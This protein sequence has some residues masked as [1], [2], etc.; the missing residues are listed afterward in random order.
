MERIIFSISI[1][2]IST[3]LN[4]QEFGEKVDASLATN[5]QAITIADFDNDGY[6]DIAS[7][8]GNEFSI[9]WAEN[10]G[11]GN[12]GRNGLGNEASTGA[13][14]DIISDDFD[15]DGDIDVMRAIS[16]LE[17]KIAWHKNDG[18]G[19]FSGEIIITVEVDEPRS[20]FSADLNGD[21]LPDLLST[22]R[23]DNK[24][25]WYKNLGDGL[26][27][28][29]I[30]I[31]DETVYGHDIEAAD[32]DLDGDLDIVYGTND[33]K[34]YLCRNNGNESFS[35]P[36]LFSTNEV[37]M[38]RGIKLIDLD[39][40]GKVDILAGGYIWGQVGWFKNLGD[41]TFSDYV[42]IT[43]MPHRVRSVDAADLD[44][45]GDI[46]VVYASQGTP[47][48]GPA[49][50]SWVEN[51]GDQEYGLPVKLN[52]ETTGGTDVVI[53][54][55]NN[56][57]SLDVVSC[58]ALNANKI[59]WYENL[60]NPESLVNIVSF[61][62]ENSNGI[63][64]F[65]ESHLANVPLV[66]NPSGNVHYTNEKGV[67][68]YSYNHLETAISGILP[69]NYVHTNSAI[70]DL[71]SPTSS[72]DTLYIG[73]KPVSVDNKFD[74]NLTIGKAYCN[75]NSPVIVSFQNRGTFMINGSIVLRN[76]DYLE[77]VD[78]SASP[79]PSEV[80]LDAIKWEVKDLLPG[81]TFYASLEFKVDYREES[82]IMLEAESAV[83][84][85]ESSDEIFV[86][87]M[88]TQ[89]DSLVTICHCTGI[90]DK[91]Y[92][93]LN[94]PISAVDS[95]GNDDHSLHGCDIIGVTDLNGD[96]TIDEEDC[97]LKQ[98][99]QD[100]IKIIAKTQETIHCFPSPEVDKMSNPTGEG[101]ANWTLTEQ[102]IEYTIRF[103]NQ[104]G[105]ERTRVTITDFIDENLDIST[106]K[107]LGASHPDVRL[108]LINA[109][110]RNQYK[111]VAD[112]SNIN[113][114]D[115]NVDFAKSQGFIKYSIEPKSFLEDSTEIFNSAKV[116]FDKSRTRKITDTVKNTLVYEI[117]A[118]GPHAFC[119]DNY[120]FF[121]F[122]GSSMEINA[123]EL[124]DGSIDNEGIVSYEVSPAEFD[125]GDLGRPHNV[126]LKVFDIDGNCDSCFTIVD[127]FGD[128]GYSVQ[129]R[130]IAIDVQE[131]GS[132][133]IS[134]LDLTDVFTSG[135]SGFPSMDLS[136]DIFTSEDEGENQIFVYFL[137]DFGNEDSCEAIVTVNLLSDVYTNYR[138]VRM[139]LQPNPSNSFAVLKLELDHPR[140][141]DVSI[142]DLSGKVMLSYFNQFEQELYLDYSILS[143]GIYFLQLYD[144]QTNK[145]MGYL[146]LLKE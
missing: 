132:K 74:L 96:E 19:N 66:I 107:F 139:S 108:Q 83:L 39:L 98:G 8:D 87:E 104:S 85:L 51:L 26:F 70:I 91:P 140:T 134:P 58:H 52:D 106:F 46:D 97:I 65:S 138:D 99:V 137:N 82:Q 113:L 133:M 24:I 130:D 129:C 10:G 78:N 28:N 143:K 120:Q 75:R 121:L 126:R 112:I 15:L 32:L 90:S 55:I 95:L 69:K 9:L 62:D 105:V 38:P 29:Q 100:T 93:V 68:S 117:P 50:V 115:D 22:S 48:V 6:L 17:D 60:M 136:K 81:A 124:D 37:L 88:S 109:P 71:T 125:C 56:D 18:K 16:G 114:P 25:A 77:Y 20:L 67:L 86:E 79:S 141:Y 116:Y 45:D 1:F 142:V 80:N 4:G 34:F 47:T 119:V 31:S 94:L 21:G 43:G 89:F 11:C 42:D 40:D 123:E 64:D 63:K 73:M 44:S 84:S 101:L 92:Q 23:Y 30:I 72:S 13:T 102:G 59:Y 76:F 33:H 111:L 27:S 145:P 127:L 54:D 5:P 53:A 57:A 146:K 103:Q 35:E 131:G 61:L 3:I 49:E 2:L 41:A 118:W 36:E 135:C 110:K 144:S 122:G 128:G 7:G 12:F 14:L